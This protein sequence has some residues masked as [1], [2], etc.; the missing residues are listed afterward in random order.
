[1]NGRSAKRMREHQV[2]F[3]HCMSFHFK[4]YNSFLQLITTEQRRSTKKSIG[5]Y[6]ALRGFH[7][8]VY[9]TS[10]T[11]GT[12][13]SS[14]RRT[15]T[16]VGEFIVIRF[17]EVVGD[18]VDANHF[19]TVLETV[20]ITTLNLIGHDTRAYSRLLNAG[21]TWPTGAV[22]PGLQVFQRT[23]VHNYSPASSA[24]AP[25]TPNLWKGGPPGTFSSCSFSSSLT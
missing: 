20:L 16:N 1:M 12:G 7:E 25:R 19:R 22:G 14:K 11:T 18:H 2:R 3:I 6:R 13:L 23:L 24:T 15:A 9:G 4:T 5:Y 10:P 8:A 21:W 17:A